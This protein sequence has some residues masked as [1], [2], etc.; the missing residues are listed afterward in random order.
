M[1][2]GLLFIES[3]VN[4]LSIKITCELESKNPLIATLR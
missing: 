4:F 3:P 1:P 2:Q